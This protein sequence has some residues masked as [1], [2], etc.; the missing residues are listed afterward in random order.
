MEA[1]KPVNL[2]EALLVPGLSVHAVSG[3]LPAIRDVLTNLLCIA[4]PL[5][6]LAVWLRCKTNFVLL[7]NQK[8]IECKTCGTESGFLQVSPSQT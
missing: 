5:S 8:G 6:P 4:V 2:L 7:E 1:C 3:Y